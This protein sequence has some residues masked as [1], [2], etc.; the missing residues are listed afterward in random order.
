[1]PKTSEDLR[2]MHC[3]KEYFDF[4]QIG[5]DS[6]GSEYWSNR[7]LADMAQHLGAQVVGI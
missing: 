3:Q 7:E 1:M 6:P 5:Y 2:K 4:L